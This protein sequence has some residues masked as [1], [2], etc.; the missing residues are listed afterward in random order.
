MIHHFSSCNAK[1]ELIHEEKSDFSQS[2]MSL[3]T[4]L[5]HSPEEY[6]YHSKDELQGNWDAALP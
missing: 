1:T 3:N 4:T 6:K 5:S 2:W